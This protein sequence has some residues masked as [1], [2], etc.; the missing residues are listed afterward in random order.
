MSAWIYLNS[1]ENKIGQERRDAEINYLKDAKFPDSEKFYERD[2]EYVQS[3]EKI[4]NMLNDG[5]A[6]FKDWLKVNE[7]NIKL[8]FGRATSNIAVMKNY[9]VSE[10]TKQRINLMEQLLDARKEQVS[11]IK[12][13]AQEDNP[14]NQLKLAEIRNKQTEILTEINKKDN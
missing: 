11:I 10:S 7:E 13:L 5:T 8:E 9:N 12:Q 4:F 3:D 6:S 14:A 1:P 2:K